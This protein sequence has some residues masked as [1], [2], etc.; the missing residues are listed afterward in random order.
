MPLNS[1]SPGLQ[2]GQEAL[3]SFEA[4]YDRYHMQV[5]RYLYAHLKHEHDTAD[6]MQQVFFQAWKQRQ[7]YESGRGSVATWLF[8]IAHHRLVDFYRVS[9]PSLSWESIPEI[10]AIDQNPEEHVLSAETIAQVRRLLEALSQPE[11]E[12]LALR[13]AA[14]LSSAKIASIIGKSEAATKKQLTRLLSRLQEQYRRQ[15]LDELLPVL[16][17]PTLPAF[18]A[19][20]HQV[21]AAPLP[22][23]R[24]HA[25]RQNLLKQVYPA[26]S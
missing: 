11:Q 9:H 4:L 10:P 25:I 21:Y 12:L 20:L 18:V 24:V 3:P 14:R 23:L 8:S 2:H 26:F 7:T 17:E 6:L 5:Y 16:L 22:T 19:A 13:F 15:E 1:P